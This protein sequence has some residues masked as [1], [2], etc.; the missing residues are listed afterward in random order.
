L[1]VTG[2]ELLR[3]YERLRP[4]HNSNT[5]TR[6]AL[7]LR[8]GLS[9]NAV[10]WRLRRAKRQESVVAN[11]ATTAQPPNVISLQERVAELEAELARRNAEAS[12]MYAADPPQWDDTPKLRQYL[13]T[14][15]EGEYRTALLW[16]DQHYPD[17]CQQAI[18][19]GHQLEAVVKPDI[20]VLMGDQFDLDALGRFGQS[21]RRN[22]HDAFEEVVGP[23]HRFIDRLHAP[24]AAIMGNHDG[25]KSGR[26]AR[27]LDEV[28]APL[29]VT[30]EEAY[31]D[32]IRA[33]GKVWYLGG[34]NEV[35]INSIVL[36]HGTR[37]GE[38][39]A[40]NAL[41]DRGFGLANVGVHT[42]FPSLS[43]L[44]QD[45]PGDDDAYRVIM[46][47][48]LG[49]LGNRL[50]HYVQGTRKTRHIHCMGVATFSLE[51]WIANTELIVFHPHPDGSLVA[52]YGGHVLAQPAV[53]EVRR[54]A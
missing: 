5:A 40:K 3:E 2:N 13:A 21:R 33:G 17:D 24:V 45:V 52:F 53:S 27:A 4:E 31:V 7:G 34:M 29:A 15:R 25:T 18:Q 36:Q 43:I 49:T 38:Y 14:C 35:K 11:F 46:S 28:F 37:T 1:T 10:R 39:A 50:S 19:L 44:S 30:I 41:K 12:A 6:R 26:V 48:V 51:T 22:H 20:N 54:A 8:Y 47:A 32:I 23:Y 42:H 9:E 16:P